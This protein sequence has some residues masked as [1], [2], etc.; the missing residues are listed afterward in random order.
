[1]FWFHGRDGAL[2]VQRSGG[3][4]EGARAEPPKKFCEPVISMAGFSLLSG[5]AE[6]GEAFQG[7][8]V[9]AVQRHFQRHQGR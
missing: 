2:L 1:M 7:E 3:D 8:I 9:A 5:E 4:K 6:G